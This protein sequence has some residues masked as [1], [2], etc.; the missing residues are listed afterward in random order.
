MTKPALLS[1]LMLSLVAGCGHR[2]STAKC[3]GFAET[4]GPCTFEPVANEPVPVSAFERLD[5]E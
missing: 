1:L 3:F 2:P 5:N 4:D